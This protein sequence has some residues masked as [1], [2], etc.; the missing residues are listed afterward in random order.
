AKINDLGARRHV[1]VVERSLQAHRNLAASNDAEP[2]ARPACPQPLCPLRPERSSARWRA[3]PLRW[4]GALVG[5]AALQRS[6]ESAVR[7]PERFRTGCAFG[8]PRCEDTLH[9]ALIAMARS[10][11]T[12][13]IS[14]PPN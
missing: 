4:V 13:P 14:W 2:P 12:R 1:N 9:T 11:T 5:A 10:Y 8:G 3:A 7:V 6:R